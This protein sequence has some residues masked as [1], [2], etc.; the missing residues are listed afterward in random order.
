MPRQ[1]VQFI[2]PTGLTVPLA[3]AGVLIGSSFL[4][5]S[6]PSPA[7]ALPSWKAIFRL[8]FPFAARMTRSISSCRASILHFMNKISGDYSWSAPSMSRR[9]CGR[10]PPCEDGNDQ[11]RATLQGRPESHLPISL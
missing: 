11:R 2:D 8:A 5:A 1:P 3:I 10:S 9:A 6:T 7:P 4:R